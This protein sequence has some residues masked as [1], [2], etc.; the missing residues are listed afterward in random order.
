MVSLYRVFVSI[1]FSITGVIKSSLNRGLRYIQ[2]RYMR[3]RLRF[4]CTTLV[5][6]SHKLLNYL[7]R[8]HLV[9]HKSMVVFTPVSRWVPGNDW[10][11][12]LTHGKARLPDDIFLG[13]PTSLLKFL[14][15]PEYHRCGHAN[16]D[17]DN[18]DDDDDVDEDLLLLLL[19]FS[20]GYIPGHFMKQIIYDGVVCATFL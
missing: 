2:V 18:N 15:C 5:F 20:G 14:R 12:K 9:F 16:N 11:L 13:D 17:S 10:L 1:Y 3:Q 6:L 4:R 8:T 19:L 7:T